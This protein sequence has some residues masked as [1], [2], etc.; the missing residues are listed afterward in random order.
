M[1]G[2]WVPAKDP[3]STLKKL[4]DLARRRELATLQQ[5][6]GE[7]LYNPDR[8]VQD[9]AALIEQWRSA[10]KATPVRMVSAAGSDLAADVL[11][12]SES[13]FARRKAEGSAVM[14]IRTGI[15][16]LDALMNGF[17]PGLHVLGGAP[18]AG[19]T[20]LALQMAMQAA[21]SGVPALYLTYENTPANLVLKA[22]CAEADIAP[23]DVE[24]GFG[25]PETL[26]A[27]A[28]TLKPAL[29]KVAFVEGTLRL[30]TGAIRAL[31][32][33]WRT[34][35]NAPRI[36]IIVDYLQRAAHQGGYELLRQNVSRLAAELREISSALSSPVL[37]LA[38]Q[39]RS[40]GDYGKGGGSAN[41]DSLKESGDLE[42]GADSVMFLRA[43]KSR[44]LSEPF[45]A[46]E[47][48]LVKNRFGPLG[49]VPLVYRADVG[50]LYEDENQSTHTIKWLEDSVV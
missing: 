5:Q 19:K 33:D 18:G 20:T 47:I 38:S 50:E 12:E 42:Y 34:R 13:R 26:S 17:C 2:T 10:A 36:L 16:R 46:I 39:N 49:A 43:N 22:I 48:A 37:A 29:D 7:V 11:R 45:R 40:G 8:P 15:P 30:S 21:S 31:A 25:K 4:Q 24:R 27:A 14:G 28:A 41:L 9:A 44:T 3:A 35:H 32:E 6:I 23:L 1:V